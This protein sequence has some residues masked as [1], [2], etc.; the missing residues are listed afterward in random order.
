MLHKNRIKALKVPGA[1]LVFSKREMKSF[2]DYVRRFGAQGLG[3]F[4]MKDDGLISSMITCMK[5]RQADR[6]LQYLI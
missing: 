4:Q 3:Y 5:M 2:E 1:D 6:F